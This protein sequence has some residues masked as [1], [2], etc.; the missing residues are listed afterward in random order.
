MKDQKMFSSEVELGK[1]LGS[2]DVIQDAYRPNSQTSSTHQ[3]HPTRSGFNVL[4]FNS[5]CD[6]TILINNSALDLV[7]PENHKDLHFLSTK[8][9]PD[10]SINKAAIEL[11]E[12]H[13]DELLELLKQHKE[14][15]LVVTGHG[16]K[17]AKRPIC[18][19]FGAPLLGDETLRRAI[20]E[21]P[22]WNSC[23][24]NVVAN[25]DTLASVYSSKTLYKPFGTFLFCTE[26]GGHTA[27]EDQETILAVLDDIA[28]SN[29]G[30]TQMHDYTNDLGLIRR[31][32]LYRGPSKFGGSNLNP[33]TTD[34]VLQ[35]QEIGLLKDDSQD[36][37]AKT[38]EKRAKMI[39]TK[40][41][42]NA[43]EPTKK[44]NEMKISLT[45]MEW[46]MKGQRSKGGYYDSFKNAE[47]KTIEEIRSQQEII[48]NQRILSQYWKKTIEEK[49]LMPQKEGAELRKR[50]LYGGTNYR[51]I[52]EPLDIADYYKKGN[53]N[54]IDSRPNHYVLLERWSEDDKKDQK[55]SDKKTKAA[56]LTEDSCF[57]AHVEEA[58]ISL[59]DLKNGG[60]DDITI[61]LKTT[62]LK[63]FEEDVLRAI[64]DFSLSPKVFVPGS[65][66]MKW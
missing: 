25:T 33:L 10:F 23:F 13:F 28:S 37:I 45:Y 52:V 32:I 3:L 5:L 66:L 44:L 36:L 14:S 50:W 34:I 6:Y 43:Y 62:N 16:L 31:K 40:R 15:P 20:C 61:N 19:T 57:W 58:L 26:S 53:T 29:G 55:P 21:R 4:A 11:F 1:F 30:N 27:F 54:Y 46:Y 59:R 47:T 17:T 41:M 9:N 24:L 7:S 35:F 39:K 8:V 56:S 12:Q 42:V 48:R 63:R 2:T 51:R 65:S 38:K 49:E 22:Q 60:L 18:I 64:K